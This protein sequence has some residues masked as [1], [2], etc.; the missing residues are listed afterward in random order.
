[1]SLVSTARRRW[2]WRHP[3]L[4]ARLTIA[5][6]AM[7]V[8]AIVAASLLLAWRVHASLLDSLDRAVQ[9]RATDTAAQAAQ[10]QLAAVGSIGADSTALVQV[11]TAD[12]RVLASSANIDGEPA[13]FS[14]SAPGNGTVAVRQAV[15]PVIGDS[16][17]FRVAAVRATARGSSVTVYAA[18]STAG[19][20]ATTNQLGAALLVGDP[21]LIA[22]LIAVAWLLIGRALRPVEMMRAQVEAISG[23]VVQ[24]RLQAGPARDELHRL[25]DTFNDLLSRIEERSAQ[26]LRFL[27]DAAHELRNPVASLHARLDVAAQHPEV[28][29]TAEDG[30]QLAASAARL[31]SL[32]DS[33]LS[34]AQLDAHRPMRQEPVDIDDLIFDHIE[35]L[36]TSSGPHLDARRV[37][38]A[39]IVGDRSALDRVVSNLLDNAMRHAATRVSIELYDDG[40]AVTV[41]VA[42]DGPGVPQADRDR[43]FERFVR[44]DNE[45]ATDRG[46]AGLGL[47][48]VRDVIDAHNGR[49]HIEDNHPGARVVVV[50]PHPGDAHPLGHT[51]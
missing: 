21:I 45:Q 30:H 46:G 28:A 38:G 42:D 37:S 4:R 32:V 20:D 9:Q 31:A 44:L 1:M 47:A 29:L 5:S 41:V 39:Q 48:I 24:R 7:I 17:K 43:V 35:R 50:I 27:A 49:A 14:F 15:S 13:L 16:D 22:A 34:L 36:T 6:T 11:V 10:G 40:D 23:S 12:G 26:Q 19:I 33:L 8:V 3:S 51:S 18:Q 2:A 25:A